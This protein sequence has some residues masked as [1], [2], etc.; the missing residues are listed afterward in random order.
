M[1]RHCAVSG[2]NVKEKQGLM[3]FRFPKEPERRAKWISLVNR[4]NWQPHANSTLCEIHFGKDQWEQRR[5][6]G[7]RKLQCSA[8]PSLLCSRENSSP[9]SYIPSL[10]EHNYCR[11]SSAP[12]ATFHPLILLQRSLLKDVSNTNLN[13]TPIH[14]ATFVTS[15]NLPKKI[16]ASEIQSSASSPVTDTM[17]EESVEA[18]KER[19]ELKEKE[20]AALQ[21]KYVSI[22]KKAGRIFTSYCNMKRQRERMKTELKRLQDFH[23]HSH[24]LLAVRLRQDQLKALCSKTTRGRKWSIPTI[25]DALVY[26][27]KLGTQTYSEF[28]R[29]FPIFPSVRT[30][31][32]A[33]EH[34]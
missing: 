25:T 16:S 12:A 14:P 23:R 15:V 7:L 20:I 4:S 24:G 30:L 8:I 10:D 1:V 32:K 29:K 9:A 31:Q 2:C 19:L 27:M 3:M 6:D 26:K 17:E 34:L 28:V 11:L 33:A 21:T 5:I 22:Q 18:L 13:N